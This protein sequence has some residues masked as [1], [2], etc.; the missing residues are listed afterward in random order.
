[1]G[2]DTLIGIGAGIGG[3]STG[4]EKALDIAEAFL[5]GGSYQTVVGLDQRNCVGGRM[6]H[7]LGDDTKLTFGGAMLGPVVGTLLDAFKKTSFFGISGEARLNWGQR[8]DLVYGGPISEIVRGPII[9]KSNF[10]QLSAVPTGLSVFSNLALIFGVGGAFTSN[11]PTL[12]S[13]DVAATVNLLAYNPVIDAKY[14]KPILGCSQVLA[15]LT[16]ACD[17]TVRFLY[18]TYQYNLTESAKGRDLAPRVVR[19][20]QRV[21]TNFLTSLIYYMELLSIH[22]N[23]AVNVQS[24]ASSSVA[25]ATAQTP[26]WCTRKAKLILAFLKRAKRFLS[27]LIRNVIVIAMIIALLAV[28]T[29]A[30][31]GILTA[32]G[33]NL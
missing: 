28:L 9:K 7:V 20:I 19:L 11:R 24:G 15:G 10:Q 6:T 5:L 32:A 25:K 2:I 33:V 1:M 31:V 12:P 3:L 4:D 8:I 27:Q 17:L 29:A 16:A 13:P 23:D 30:S 26:S 14:E 22:D 18:P 21:I